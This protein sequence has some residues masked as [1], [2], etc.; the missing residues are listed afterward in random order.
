MLKE[1]IPTLIDKLSKV[2]T[3]YAYERGYVGEAISCLRVLYD[4]LD[5]KEKEQI[6]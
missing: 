4:L 2:H 5:E 3:E 6:E 1:D